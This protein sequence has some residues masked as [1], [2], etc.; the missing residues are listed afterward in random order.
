[1]SKK[2]TIID[3]LEIL[4]KEIEYIKLGLSEVDKKLIICDI[5]AI[6]VSIEVYPN[7][8]PIMKWEEAKDY[9]KKLGD[10]WRL[11]T[12]T[13]LNIMY[14]NKESIGGFDFFYYWSSTEYDNYEAWIHSFGSGYQSS[15]GKNSTFYVRAVRDVN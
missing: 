10:G 11:P 7:S 4:H 6:Y 9:C 3:S 15:Y 12:K 14:Q 13:E 8:S 5:P 1:M 2:R